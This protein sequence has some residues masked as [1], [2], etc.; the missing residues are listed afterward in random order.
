MFHGLIHC[1]RRRNPVS[2]SPRVNHGRKKPI[3]EEETVPAAAS[4]N[5]GFAE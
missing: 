5:Y 4:L 2:G 1:F 3:T